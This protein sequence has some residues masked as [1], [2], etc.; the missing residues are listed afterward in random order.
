MVS[1][2]E[3]LVPGVAAVVLP[4]GLQPGETSRL[5]TS[6]GASMPFVIKRPFKAA[7][8]VVAGAVTRGCHSFGRGQTSPS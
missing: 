7:G 6:D 4:L 8:D 3:A 1:K 5:P 2:T